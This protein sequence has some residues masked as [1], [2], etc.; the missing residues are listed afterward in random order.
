[1]KSPRC[2]IVSLIIMLA[3][4]CATTTLGTAMNPDMK[5]VK[6][7]K[8]MV[9]A[10]FA[11]LLLRRETER[12]FPKNLKVYRSTSGYYNRLPKDCFLQSLDIIPPYK[13]Y[14]VEELNAKLWDNSIDGILVV[15]LEDYW[16]SQT[17]MPRASK[18]E[19]EIRTYGNSL[20]YESYT[21][22]S[23][24]FY[25]SKPSVKF[26]IRL[27]DVTS[28]EIIWMATSVTSGNAF[29]NYGTLMESLSMSVIKELTKEDIITK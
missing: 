28:G 12:R 16:T 11:D 10:P 25:V 4:N 15:A 1:M 5:H 17:Y 27:F 29:A 20:F 7:R 14:T 13:E 9:V 21:Q 18:T 22:E 23:G 24:G 3:L 26:D 19:G 8:I 2:M 6:L